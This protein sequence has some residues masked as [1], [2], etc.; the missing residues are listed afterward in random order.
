MVIDSMTTAL[1][2]LRVGLWSEAAEAF[3]R[4]IVETDDPRAHDGLAQAAW[5]LDDADTAL[6][7]REAG[8]RGFRAAGDDR[9]AARAAAT[10]GYDSLLFGRGVAV[11]LG[12]L[13]RAADLLDGR[14]DLPENGWL[15]V[16]QAE[17]AL[18]AEH[19]AASALEH[20]RAAEAVG[21]SA[22]DDNLVFVAQ[23]LAGLSLVRLGDVAGGMAL[24]DASTAAATTGDLDDLMWMGKICCWL[25]NACHE[26]GDL[27]RAETWCSRVEEICVARDLEPLFS[28]CR[29]QYAS[30]LLAQGDSEGAESALDDAL[31]RLDGS[32]RLARL[33]AV[34]QLG[35][36][37]RR[38]GRDDEAERLLTQAGFQPCAVISLTRLQ[39]AQGDVDRAWSTIS[40]LVRSLPDDTQ[41]D[42]VGAWSACVE[43]GVVAG[44]IGPA[45]DAAVQIREM[46]DRVCTDAMWAMAAAAEARVA[47]ESRVVG[48]WQDAIRHAAAAGLLFEEAD[49]R[50]DLAD[51]LVARGHR[52]EA[53]RHAAEAVDRFQPLGGGP[54]TIR[55]L[56]ILQERAP[57]VPLTERQVDVLR[58]LASGSSNAEIA[59]ELFLSEHTVHRHVANIY[60][61]LG[62]RTR[63][64]AAVYAVSHDLV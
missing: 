13:A 32:K 5:W 8:Y 56:T 3:G 23:A 37:R 16:R 61:A 22:G 30:V 41:L 40:E 58:L 10:L 15:A 43:V 27:T 29:I 9:A 54:G 46:A 44:Q 26:A 28:V 49:H 38:Q 55:A 6:A 4:A 25:I 60:G 18:A 17:V 57:D 24:L 51:V 21:R 2:A 42:R 52:D 48:H 19:D 12:W 39:L 47:G 33:E 53:R 1:A 62:I 11:G 64:E 34:A 7:S 45:R 20:A 31:G 36:L 50:L 35:E 59:T 63:A 14:P